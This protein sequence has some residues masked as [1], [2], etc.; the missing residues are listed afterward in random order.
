MTL[1]RVTGAG[2]AAAEAARTD[3]AAP[4]EQRHIASQGGLMGGLVG[5][6][7]ARCWVICCGCAADCSA[8]Q[9]SAWGVVR[10]SFFLCDRFEGAHMQAGAV[11]RAPLLRKRTSSWGHAVAAASFLKIDGHMQCAH[12]LQRPRGRLQ[13]G[14]QWQLPCAHCAA[15]PCHPW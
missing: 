8:G 15:T 13:G 2:A 3:K 1:I 11:L 5:S 10:S 7:C 4:G 14:V 6:G 9:G 12:Q